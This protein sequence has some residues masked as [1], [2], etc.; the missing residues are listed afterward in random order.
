MPTDLAAQQYEI[1]AAVDRA[2]MA[3]HRE[4]SILDSCAEQSLILALV[5]QKLVHSMVCERQSAVLKLQFLK[6]GDDLEKG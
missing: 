6:K 3:V 1:D 5:A 2:V 4:A